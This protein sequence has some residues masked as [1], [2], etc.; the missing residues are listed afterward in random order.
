[1]ARQSRTDTSTVLWHDDTN[2]LGNRFRRGGFPRHPV[3]PAVR[4]DERAGTGPRFRRP[5]AR[6]HGGAGPAPRRRPRSAHRRAT[7]TRLQEQGGR[8]D[9]GHRSAAA[10]PVGPSAH[11]EVP[12][13]PYTPSAAL[14]AGAGQRWRLALRERL[15][16]WVQTRCGLERRALGALAVLL[17]AG[18]ALAAYGFGAGRPETVRA[19]ETVGHAATTATTATAPAEPPPPAAAAP[20]PTGPPPS[21]DPSAGAVVVDV[22]GRVRRPGVLRLPPGSRVVDALR[23]AGGVPPGTDTTG[24]NRARVLVDGE[25]VLVGVPA[26]GPPGAPPPG[27]PADTTGTGTAEGPVSLNTATVEQLDTLPG[28]GP[29]LARHIVEHRARHGGFRSIEELREVHGIGA[30][31]FADLRPRV[32]L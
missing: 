25:H 30:R 19:P 12:V 3:L 13:P 8:A 24:L 15:P 6:P 27:A 31:R 26:A 29:V 14:P 18:V 23:A 2:T 21:A 16:V 7:R 32:R 22:S 20:P 17:V 10:P 1:M 9:G 4:G 11:S 28:V 5:D